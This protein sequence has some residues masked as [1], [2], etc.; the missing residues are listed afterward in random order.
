VS[1]PTPSE[2]AALPADLRADNPFAAPSALPYGLPAFGEVHAEHY[3]PALEA[4]M[5]QQRAQVEAIATAPELPTLANTVEAIERSGRLLARVSAVFFNLSA[6]ASTP[7]LREIEAT[8]APLLAAH[9]D[10]MYLDERI[11]ARVDAVHAARHDTGPAG[12]PLLT[13]EQV[14]LAERY[15]RDFVR[16]GAGLPPAEAARLRG[17]NAELSTLTTRF[18]A[19]LLAETEH[20]ALRLDSAEELAGL[21]ADAVAAAMAA[22]AT[23]G[24]DGWLLT[25][26]LPTQQPALALLRD[27]SVRQR[28]YTAAASRGG[29]GG[30]HDTRATL[31]RVARLRAERAALL[32]YPSHADYVIA[33][34]TAGSR[35]AA[36]AMLTGMINPALENA[37]AE[38]RELDDR[39]IADGYR[40]P[41]E[42][43][44]WAYYAE[45]VRRE[46]FCLD[47]A[48]LRVYLELHRTL[49]EGV[50]RAAAG[51]YGLSFQRRRDL[52]GYAPD[53][54]VYEVFDADGQGCGLLLGDWFVR[55]G[56]AGGAWM[57]S[58]VRQSHL[59]GDRPVVVVNAN[60]PRPP[61]GEPALLTPDLVRTLFHECGHALHGLLSDVTYPRFSGTSVPRDFVEF[62]SQVNEMWAWWP[63][64]LAGYAVHH[65]TGEAMPR[66]LGDAL[67]A[68]ESYGQGF[69][70]TELLAAALLD[71][72]W[73]GLAADREV[74]P[75]DVAAFEQEALAH[76]GLALPQIPPR[77]RSTYFA[78][79][80]SGGY[81]AGYYSYLWSEVL[82]ADTVDWFAERGG[83][84][85]ES[86]ELFRRA[87]LS[88]GGA[89]DPM[90]AY[91]AVL[92]RPPRIEPLLERRGLLPV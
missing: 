46:R 54:E 33:D 19:D 36:T 28:L 66:E 13:A 14:R 15:H 32:G 87:L 25:L 41:L 48:A 59:L 20:L 60:V 77:Y 92:G 42:P 55:E 84:V 7:G 67:A 10:A 5:A 83:L 50:F 85:R 75:D 11:F 2:E 17:L 8:V 82:D 80:F 34:E 58:F 64:V 78:H 35:E 40:E 69:G 18:H 62:P 4:G 47:Q 43:W 71:L 31:V 16:A 56:K 38:G 76:H 68:A 74:N 65:L 70:T 73:H 30:E 81:G 44:D 88:R 12:D 24:L 63:D 39:L 89:V 52:A 72:A 45:L 90:E 51:L 49:E 37:L 22:A 9:R 23:R 29:R 57:N 26:A 61:E 21:S 53:V 91:A 86:G 27:R 1:T 3:L 6:A 79:I